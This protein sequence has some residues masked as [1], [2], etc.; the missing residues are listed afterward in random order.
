MDYHGL[1][2]KWHMRW[3]IELDSTEVLVACKNRLLAVIDRTVG[4]FLFERPQVLEKYA[5]LLGQKQPIKSA[6]GLAALAKAMRVPDLDFS[7]TTVYK[8]LNSASTVSELMVAL[9]ALFYVLDENS[10]PGIIRLADKVQ[11]VFDASSQIELRVVR[12][13]TRI[14][15]YPKGAKLLDE[16]VV[17]KTLAWLCRYPKVLSH[18]DNALK[19][20]LSKDAA[21]YRN[22]LDDLRKAIEELLRKVLH[23]RKSLENQTKP[24]M[25]WLEEKGIHPQVRNLYGQLLFG[26]Y[27]AYQNEAVKHGDEWSEDDLE[28]IIYL[29]ATFMYYLLQLEEPR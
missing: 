25:K 1:I 4:H 27:S 12:K 9:Q 22:L 10:C 6:V 14:D 5:F 20:Y 24:L 3:N 21:K 18:F 2:D 23:N 16:T 29:S 11:E 19:T 7:Q 26:P 13:N 28:F 17:N 8:T 15:L